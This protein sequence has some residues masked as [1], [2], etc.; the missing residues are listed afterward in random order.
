VAQEELGDN[1]LAVT[2]LSPIY[3][4]R[5]I[6][7]AADTAKQLGIRHETLP[8]QVL[9]IPGVVENPP[10]R[11]YHCK[12]ALFQAMVNLARERGFTTVADGTNADDPAEHRPGMTALKELGV[13]S[14][15]RDA[16]LAKTDIRTLSRD[17]GLPTADKPSLACLASRIPY[18]VHLTEDRLH[19][20]DTVEERLLALGF[21]QV[22]ARHHED[23]LRIEV[24]ETEIDRAVSQRDA[25]VSVG[26][27]AGFTY[28]TL[29]LE[30]YRSGSMDEKLTSTEHGVRSSE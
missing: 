16:G 13:V 9:G 23:T 14:P 25:V 4:S 24:G 15:L 7:E 10:D 17:M 21:R 18:G 28:V 1:V 29:D 22:R 27:A 26:K 12:K 3:P 8:S 2:A 20:I 30:G 5:E 11:C 6:R 19:V